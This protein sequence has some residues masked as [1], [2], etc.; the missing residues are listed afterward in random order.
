MLVSI[1]RFN[2]I[3]KT[4]FKGDTSSR[5]INVK[6]AGFFQIR[7]IPMLVTL[8]PNSNSL[9]MHGSMVAW[10]LGLLKHSLYKN[11]SLLIKIPR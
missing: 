8:T 3:K 5:F 1:T 11:R 6:E 2:Y 7:F 4:D 9:K 10:F